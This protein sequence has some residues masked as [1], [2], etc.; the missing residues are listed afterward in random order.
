MNNFQI[1]TV[2]KLEF[3]INID[4]L[5]SDFMIKNKIFDTG[6]KTTP[7]FD[8][9]IWDFSRNCF[10]NLNINDEYLYKILGQEI[11]TCNGL[12]Y[13]KIIFLKKPFYV[14]IEGL[15]AVEIFYFSVPYD[16]SLLVDLIGIDV[17]SKYTVLLSKFDGKYCIR[18]TE[19]G[20]ELWK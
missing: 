3:G 20:E 5:F 16:P 7:L 18:V 2:Y 15:R 11:Q 19:Q 13:E 1:P 9:S 10:M 4:K 6:Y 14:S 8:K 17:I 12:S